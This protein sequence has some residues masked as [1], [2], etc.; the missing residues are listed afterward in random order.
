MRLLYAARKTREA[1][2]PAAADPLVAIGRELAAALTLASCEEGTLGRRS[3]LE[4]AE[5]ALARLG[6]E[7]TIGD[8]AS[9]L[10]KVARARVVG[11]KLTVAG[12]AP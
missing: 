9:R 1:T 8:G 5:R 3:A 10:A 4:R 6:D 12:R 7:L 2:L 11:E